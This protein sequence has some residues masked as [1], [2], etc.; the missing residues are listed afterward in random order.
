MGLHGGGIV[1]QT[2]IA[3]V[4]EGEVII[5]PRREPSPPVAGALAGLMASPVT[6]NMYGDVSGDK[7][8]R[9]FSDYIGDA[10]RRARTSGS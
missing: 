7:D 5:N 9:T 2:G 1:A 8:M 10:V 3:E 4:E 6:V